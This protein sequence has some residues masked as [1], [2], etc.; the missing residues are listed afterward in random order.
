MTNAKVEASL[1]RDLPPILA[2][3]TMC[4]EAQESD[5]HTIEDALRNG[6]AVIDDAMV[7]DAHLTECRWCSEP[8]LLEWGGCVV[9]GVWHC[10]DCG[11]VCGDCGKAERAE[12]EPHDD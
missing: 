9:D 7:C 12:R 1:P 6:W 8:A 10:R 3:C 4:D 2:V 5:R 11:R